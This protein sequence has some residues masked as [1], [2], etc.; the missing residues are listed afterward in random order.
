MCL[1]LLT[2]S[3]WHDGLVYK[4][5]AFGTRGKILSLF[6]DFLSNR[7]QYVALNGQYSEW[8]DVKA[9]VP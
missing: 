9:G 5:K 3:V 7:T 6:K 4:L 8:K 1:K 2:R